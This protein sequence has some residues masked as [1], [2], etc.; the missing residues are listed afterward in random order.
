[1]LKYLL[2]IS[3]LFIIGCS[4]N[5]TAPEDK[6]TPEE[7]AYIVLS[8]SDEERSYIELFYLVTDGKG[9]PLPSKR[10]DFEIIE[11]DATLSKYSDLTNSTLRDGVQVGGT[12]I[13]YLYKK[14]ST[15]TVKV[16]ATVY[17]YNAS[18]ETSI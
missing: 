18:V 15:D 11:G 3:M 12:V 9:N 16:K 13:V 6:E 10:V 8:S 7:E 2:V 17:G 5:S 14:T 4:D 1:M